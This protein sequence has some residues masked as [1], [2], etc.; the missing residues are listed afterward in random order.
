MARY[1]IKQNS[2]ESKFVIQS[3]DATWRSRILR[4]FLPQYPLCFVWKDVEIDYGCCLVYDSCSSAYEVLKRL[5]QM[6]I[7]KDEATWT[8]LDE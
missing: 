1:R 5:R 8:I 2:D 3:E 6:E 4:F 7:D